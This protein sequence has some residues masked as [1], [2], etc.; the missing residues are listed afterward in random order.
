MHLCC[1]HGNES[2]CCIYENLEEILIEFSIWHNFFDLKSI[3]FIPKPPLRRPPGA[4]QQ[5]RAR[6]GSNRSE[7]EIKGWGDLWDSL[8]SDGHFQKGWTPLLEACDRGHVGICKILLQ[9][10]ARIDVF[11]D[12]GRT[13]GKSHFLMR[14]V[15]FHVFC[16]IIFP[17]KCN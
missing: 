11:D 4:G 14:F 15:L 12:N 13:V 3:F 1:R 9:H 7:Q 16:Q 5:N 10:H 2:I 8:D 17:G 6:R